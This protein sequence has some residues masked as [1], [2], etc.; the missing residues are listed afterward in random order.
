MTNHSTIHSA[1]PSLTE[2]RRIQRKAEEMR[3]EYIRT[4]FRKLT[5]A[6]SG[7]GRAPSAHLG[8]RRA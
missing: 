7:L 4:G 3:A 2:M 1:L 5:T 6:L 8:E